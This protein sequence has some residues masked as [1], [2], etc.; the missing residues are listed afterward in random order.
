MKKA[1]GTRTVRAKSSFSR[2]MPWLVA[3]LL[4]LGTTAWAQSEQAPEQ[5]SFQ[6][7]LQFAADGNAIEGNLDI[8][9]RLYTNE[10]DPV[11]NAV[12]GERH[13][14]VQVFGGVFNVYL[15]TGVAIDN[16]PHPTLAE[17]MKT[18]GLWLGIKVGFD[19]EMSQRQQ[20]VSVPYA[21]SAT[22]ASV[23]KNGMPPGTIVAF[24]GAAAPDG[25]LLC[26]GA[27]FSQSQYPALYAAIGSTWGGNTS[28]FNVPDLRGRTPIGSGT[29]IPANTDG[30]SAGLILR[31]P[32]TRVGE[33]SHVLTLAEIAPHAHSYVDHFAFSLLKV[34]GGA[35]NAADEDDWV[36]DSRTTGSTGSNQAHNE[37]QPTAS[38]NFII[39][40]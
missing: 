2:S 29:G 10:A 20:M 26:D 35:Y 12:W 18:A 21:L 28:S 30:G 25:W 31:T 22:H 39:K 27:G 9:F 37:M 15:G 17:A 38:I 24:A 33:E 1:N 4:V 7:D 13:A 19:E 36:D 14:G 11:A 16:V 6:G 40:Y 8:E 32:T 34:T 23:A 3:S 5:I